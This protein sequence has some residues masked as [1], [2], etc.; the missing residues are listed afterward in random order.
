MMECGV[1]FSES[2]E[3]ITLRLEREQLDSFGPTW[4][5]QRCPYAYRFILKNIRNELGEVDWDHVTAALPRRFQRVWHHRFCHS[6]QR[7]LPRSYRSKSEVRCLLGPYRDLLYTFLVASQ[8][9]EHLVREQIAIRL[10]RLAQRGNLRAVETLL[11]LLNNLVDQWL[12][13]EP[14]M[15]RWLFNNE[16]L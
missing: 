15:A 13:R 8:Y 9:D 11:P 14:C 16:L 10:V 4:I 5:A 6:R 1:D 2:I 12:D 3:L 7:C